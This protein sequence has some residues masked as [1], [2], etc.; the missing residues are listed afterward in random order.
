MYIFQM[1]VACFRDSVSCFYPIYTDTT[2]PV[3]HWL[4]DSQIRTHALIHFCHHYHKKGKWKKKK[5]ERQVS[6][7][8]NIFNIYMTKNLKIH[9]F[10][11]LS[12]I[13]LYICTTP[14]LSTYLGHLG[15]LRVLL[16]LLLLLSH[17]SRVWLCATPE[18]AAH[19]APPRS[20]DSP[21]KN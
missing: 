2:R 19:Q 3:I 13:P 21:G 18:T 5:K 16:L 11:W 9:S 20:W 10:L 8:K 6:R 1:V 4:R 12:N 15:C 17:F 7:K 14:S